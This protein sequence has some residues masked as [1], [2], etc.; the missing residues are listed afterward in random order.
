M[1]DAESIDTK[2]ELKNFLIGL[3]HSQVLQ[4]LD[5]TAK[6][7]LNL[8]K[9]LGLSDS[10]IDF[11]FIKADK[12]GNL[13]SGIFHVALE[14][15]FTCTVFDASKICWTVKNEKPISCTLSGVTFFD[16]LM[17]ICRDN[18]LSSIWKDVDVRVCFPPEELGIDTPL[19]KLLR[20]I[21]VGAEE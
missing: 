8:C 17:L 10:I 18:P 12:A 7:F 4:S 1:I 11:K 21:G 19:M 13:D 14:P 20:S 16:Y 6:R 9:K 5:K 15:D 3:D 2:L